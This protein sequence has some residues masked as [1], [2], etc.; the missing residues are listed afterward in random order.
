V[1]FDVES[2]QLEEDP[3]GRQRVED[4]QA[5]ANPST[6]G[7]P[8]RPIPVRSMP[9][10]ARWVVW[11]LAPLA[12][13]LLAIQLGTAFSWDVRNYHYYNGFAY[14]EDRMGHDLAP[15]ARQTFH[16]PALDVPFYLAYQ[17]LRGPWSGFLLGILHGLNIPLLFVLI[18]TAIRNPGEPGGRALV[19]LAVATAGILHQSFL[20]QA[21]GAAQDNIVS[22]FVLAALI[23]IVRGLR[24]LDPSTGAMA[25]RIAAA[26]GLLGCAVGLKP[27]AAIFAAGAAVA[28]GLLPGS[29]W[30]G[31]GLGLIALAGGG[32][33]GTLVTGGFWALRMGRLTGNPIFPYLNQ[34]FRSDLVAPSS[35]EYRNF[36]S[37]ETLLWAEPE[38]INEELWALRSLCLDDLRFPVVF[39]LFFAVLVVRF[40]RGRL[41]WSTVIDERA[42]ALLALFFCG[43]FVVWLKVFAINRYI[44]TLGLLAPLVIVFLFES[45]VPHHR[46]R[47]VV[48]AVLGLALAVGVGLETPKRVPWDPDPFRVDL[49]GSGIGDDALVVMID[50]APTSYVIPGFPRGARFVRP[51][52]NLYLKPGVRLWELITATIRNHPGP[53]FTLHERRPRTEG[54]R[55]QVLDELGLRQERDRCITLRDRRIVDR[56]VLCP[57]TRRTG[58]APAP[59]SRPVD[60]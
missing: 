34:V 12:L 54:K 6:A 48:F 59:G 56:L 11:L 23:L 25:A 8:G 39:S 27:T 52:G 33:A 5:G 14:V 15:A 43:S 58:P 57:A 40:V 55:R 42:G 10:W 30:R 21:G 2:G 3:S 36:L 50:A 28:V 24:T 46:I 4:G 45:V 31:R 53:V 22:L 16:N 20:V 7:D 18:W 41:G 19:A 1:I 60:G 38:V 26:G 32:V 35:Y 37:T 49:T 17:H 13:G 29:T 51:A 44:L 9:R 47:V